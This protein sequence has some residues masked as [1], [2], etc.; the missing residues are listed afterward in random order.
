ENDLSTF[1]SHLLRLNDILTHASDDSLVLIDEIGAGT[2]PDEGAAL[3]AAILKELTE[4]RAL[5]IATTHHGALKAFAHQLTGMANG[6][7]AFDHTTLRP[8]YRFRVGIP[9]SSYALELA[10]RFGF[11][12]A[13]LAQAREQLG[14]EQSR[15]ESLLAELEAQTETNRKE[16]LSAEQERIRLQSLRESY[17]RKMSALRDEISSLREKAAEEAKTLVKNAQGTIERA[18]KEIRESAAQRDRVQTARREL[19]QIRDEI[20]NLQETEEKQTA[21][22]HFA[23]GDTVRLRGGTERGELVELRGEEA[24]VLWRNGKLRVP[25]SRITKE[26]HTLAVTTEHSFPV[27]TPEATTEVDLRGMVGDEAIQKVQRFLDDAAVAGF[28]RVD[29]IHGKGTGALR[30]RVTEFLKHHPNVKSFRL[31]EWNEGGSGVTVVE[32]ES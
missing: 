27:Y 9:G 30:K 19:Q 5:T 8:T 20:H 7:L 25:V 10:E 24:I 13:I 1:S 14:I 15:L 3:G 16:L 31:G 17:E 12:R 23:P 11:S 21:G 26:R 2:D 28:H 32:L 18:V 6:S 29:I 22:E 4:R